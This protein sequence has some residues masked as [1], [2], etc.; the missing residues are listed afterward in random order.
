MKWGEQYQQKPVAMSLAEANAILGGP[1]STEEAITTAYRQAAR[2][3]H[4]DTAPEVAL[5]ASLEAGT[6]R[7]TISQLQEARRVLLAGLNQGQEITCKLCGGSG[8]VNVGFGAPCAA[9]KGKGIV[10]G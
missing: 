7:I 8:R 10:N 9:C 2:S 3:I 6:A 4:P 5:G 1:H